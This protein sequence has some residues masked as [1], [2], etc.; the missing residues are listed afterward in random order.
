METSAQSFEYQCIRCG[1]KISYKEI[2]E[3]SITVRNFSC[4]YCNSRILIKIKRPA[5]KIVKAE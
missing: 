1:R 3:R 2:L 4:I 5:A